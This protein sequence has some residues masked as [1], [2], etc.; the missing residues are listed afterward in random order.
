[1]PTRLPGMAS[2]MI[3]SMTCPFCHNDV[4]R[5]A[6]VCRGCQAEIEYGTPRWALPLT[7]IV[8]VIMSI[9]AGNLVGSW[10]AWLSFV[11]IAAAGLVFF[12]KVFAD[13][14]NFAR[15]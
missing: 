14:V 11:A 8:S 4:P 6:V 2:P 5:G 12:R 7:F 13:R 1:H 15:R 9:A 3:D 10:F